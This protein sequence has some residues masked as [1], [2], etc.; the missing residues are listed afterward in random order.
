MFEFQYLRFVKKKAS[1][2]ADSQY[3]VFLRIKNSLRFLL[4]IIFAP[5]MIQKLSY[6]IF[7]LLLAVMQLSAQMRPEEGF[8]SSFGSSG[9]EEGGPDTEGHD[10]KEHDGKEK[11]KSVPVVIKNW[12]IADY[13]ALLVKSELDTLLNFYHDY[14]P[15]NKVSFSNTSVGF[16]GGAYQSNDFFKRKGNSDFY[17]YRAF[18]AYAMFPGQIQYF[19]TTVPYSLLDYSQSENKNV[20]TESRFNVFHSQNVNPKLNLA[21]FYNQARSMGFYDSDNDDSK[22]HNI[23][24]FG[25]YQGDKLIT[26][27]SIIFNRQRSEEDGGVEPGQ[28]LKAEQLNL[29]MNDAYASLSNTVLHLTTEYRLGKTT[30]E[31]DEEGF[32]IEKFTPISGLIY[33]IE[34]SGN[35]RS[36]TKGSLSD[37]YFD[38]VYLN[39]K[40]TADTTKYSR[41]T[42]VFQLKFYES[43]TRKFTFGKRVFIGNEQLWYRYPMMDN[44]PEELVFNLHDGFSPDD[45]RILLQGYLWDIAPSVQYSYKPKQSNSFVGGAIYRSEGKFWQWNASGKIYFAGYRAGQTELEGIINKPLRIGSDTTSL[46]VEGSL[47]TLVPDYFEQNYYSNHFR[48]KNNFSNINEM[49][50]R[51]RIHSQRFKTTIGAN[52]ALIGNYIYNDKDALPA[53]AN[54]EMLVLS[55][56]LDKDFE[57]THW[58]VRTRVLWQSASESNYVHLPAFAAYASFNYRTLISKVMHAQLGVDARYTTRFYGDAF[59]PSTGRFYWQETQKI[60]NYPFIDFHVDLKLKR[61]R[62]FFNMMNITSGLLDGDFWAAPSYPL[63]KRTYRIGVAWSFYN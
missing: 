62:A 12:T 16:L 31:E 46:T 54:N 28:N 49:I 34:F 59:E 17:F 7:V 47:K 45:P 11:K 33:D 14:Q 58:L 44:N 39:S 25:S 1:V 19:N 43:P 42:N 57:S 13:G 38:N 53:Q 3:Y 2:C 36:F 35:K 52:Y 61:T 24:L 20:Q 48:W 60:G 8:G 27:G 51:G 56:W 30:E 21:F 22:Y 55:A 32:L 41:L 23:G 15:Y 63:Y 6:T 26:H 4:L 29:R 40:S 18:D 50:I 9:M 10:H 5:D 37:K